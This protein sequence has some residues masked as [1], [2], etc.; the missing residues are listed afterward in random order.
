[1]RYKTRWFSEASYA[2]ISARQHILHRTRCSNTIRCQLNSLPVCDVRFPGVSDTSLRSVQSLLYEKFQP[3]FL[4][5]CFIPRGTGTNVG[6]RETFSPPQLRCTTYG[7]VNKRC[8]VW[9]SSQGKRKRG[10][11][12][13]VGN[14]RCLSRGVRL[15]ARPPRILG[16]EPWP[17]VGE[18][19]VKLKMYTE[20]NYTSACVRVREA[21]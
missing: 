14:T 10:R 12:M 8:V 16:S 18:T 3:H 5:R 9:F 21:N 17:G 1:M 19:G 4:T 11:Y 7:Y 6:S 20:I 2:F 15:I 13:C